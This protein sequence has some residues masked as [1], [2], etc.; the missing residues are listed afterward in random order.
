MIL[1]LS[2]FSQ[3]SSPVL[4]QYIKN[5]LESN[6]T[7]KKETLHIH[8]SLEALRE[9]QGLFRPQVTFSASYTLAAGGRAIDF[10]IG[11][12]LNPVYNTLNALTQ[13]NQFPT[14][15]NEQIT[16][17]P[18]NFQET[19]IRIIQPL[20]NTDIYYNRKAKEALI[21]VQQA[22][23]E[24]YEQ[25]LRR[26]IKMA[27]FKYLQSLEATKIYKETKTLLQEIQRTNEKLVKNNKATRDVIFNAKYEIQNI[28]NEITNAKKNSEL[29]KAYFNFLLNRD[30]TMD[31]I[32]D[33]NII[34]TNSAISEST[35]TENALK[36][37]KELN[38]LKGAMTANEQAIKLKEA[39]R[40]PQVA[41][42]TDVGFQGTG[43]YF[44]NDQAF[45]FG[46]LNLTWDIYK[47]NQ[48][49]SQLEQI[50]LDQ[51]I[52]STQYLQVQQQ[53]QLQV[54]SAYQEFRAAEQ[55]VITSKAALVNAK[56]GFRLI[57]KQYENGATF[58]FQLAQAKTNLTNA[59]IILSIAEYEVLLK[60]VEL[61]YA[62]GL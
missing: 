36:T 24:T 58:F 10:P 16:F 5:G 43:Y 22:Q 8:K 56:E 50:K 6:L 51:E 28:E 3:S 55:A 54:K 29:A 30:L 33:E 61:E 12:L 57:K 26:D 21:T 13:T 32:V 42:V 59:K 40:L 62:R 49:K 14:I 23:K 7:L 4:D 38:Q 19:K 52:L 34:S 60:E 48:R 47:G 9:A 20:F 27:Y 25:E 37:R 35:H 31:I 44:L 18:H 46:S 15:E 17:L 45:V 11:D 53:I 2:V 41:L 1:N 39:Q